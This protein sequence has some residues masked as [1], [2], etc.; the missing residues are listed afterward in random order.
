M[1]KQALSSVVVGQLVKI[2]VTASSAKKSVYKVGR[3]MQ[4]KGKQVLVEIPKY[5]PRVV[6]ISDCKEL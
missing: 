1:T 6:W 4:V 2:N 3:V 5:R